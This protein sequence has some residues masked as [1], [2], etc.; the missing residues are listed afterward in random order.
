MLPS[1]DGGDD[2]IDDVTTQLRER[3]TEQAARARALA[4][5]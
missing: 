2:A 3:L 1:G 5:T 4:G